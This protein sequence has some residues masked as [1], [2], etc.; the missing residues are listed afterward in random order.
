MMQTSFWIFDDSRVLVETPSALLA[1]TQ[2]AEIS[3]YAQMFE[4][5]QGTALYGRGTRELIVRA[6]T[7]LGTQ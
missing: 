5:L 2:P 6:A 3:I 4:Q 7:E 1:I